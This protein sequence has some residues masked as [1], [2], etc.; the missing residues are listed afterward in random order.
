MV[1]PGQND[2]LLPLAHNRDVHHRRDAADRD[3]LREQVAN[4]VDA[5]EAK[6]VHGHALERRARGVLEAG[7]GARDD[8]KRAQA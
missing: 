8:D 1:H 3:R 2:P 6:L 7:D 5:L 4:E